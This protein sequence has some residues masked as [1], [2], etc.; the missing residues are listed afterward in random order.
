MTDGWALITHPVQLRHGV[1]C[2]LR[3]LESALP[4]ARAQGWIVLARD[5]DVLP[6]PRAK[7][8]GVDVIP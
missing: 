4:Q 7:H 6:A 5:S 2:P 8:A 3:I 1:A